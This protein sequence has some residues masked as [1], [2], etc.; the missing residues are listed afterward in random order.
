MSLG[1]FVRN[2]SVVHWLGVSLPRAW[3]RSLVGVLKSTSHAAAKSLVV[4]DS[5]RPHRRQPTRLCRPWDSPGK[6]TG[7]GC[8]FLLQ[9]MKVKSESEGA[10]SCLTLRKPVGSSI[11]GIFQ[12]RVLPW[13]VIKKIIIIF[14]IHGN[15]SNIRS[16]EEVYSNLHGWLWGV[17]DKTWTD[18]ELL[19]QMS[20]ECGFLRWNL[21]LV[22]MLWRL[23]KWQQQI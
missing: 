22:N 23:L 4:S 3:V 19:L 18:K 15:R 21:L 11:H 20:K 2:S 10:Q 14:V 5:V 16:L 6:N 9:S 12:A 13:G 1:I 17:H 7:V 8:H